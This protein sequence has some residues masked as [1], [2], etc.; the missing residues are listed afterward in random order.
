MLR[1]FGYRLVFTPKIQLIKLDT[2]KSVLKILTQRLIILTSM[3]TYEIIIGYWTRL[4]LKN[5]AY[6]II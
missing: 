2:R 4:L 6:S 5:L 1:I 3:W